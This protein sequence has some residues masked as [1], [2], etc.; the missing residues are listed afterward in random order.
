MLQL[1][2]HA[3]FVPGHGHPVI[4]PV[5]KL[6]EVITL[7]SY[8]QR[9]KILRCYVTSLY[10]PGMTS[11]NVSHRQLIPMLY[12]TKSQ[13][14]TEDQAI[15]CLRIHPSTCA[16]NLYPPDRMQ[17]L[18]GLYQSPGFDFQ[19]ENQQL[20]FRFSGETHGVGR[21]H[22]ILSLFTHIIVIHPAPCA[23]VFG[24]NVSNRVHMLCHKYMYCLTSVLF[25]LT[26]HLQ[27][28][29]PD[30]TC[31]G[32]FLIYLFL[33]FSDVSYGR[34]IAVRFGFNLSTYVQNRW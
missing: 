11:F 33:G 29:I 9:T 4:L 21:C 27:G 17:Q 3:E 2:M 7:L 18:N 32:T 12:C 15:H 16:F 22:S 24:Y 20:S 6:N 8:I 30:T 23:P 26:D 10:S 31:S 25:V 5:S 19:L 13:G 28:N 14:N 34:F 1:F